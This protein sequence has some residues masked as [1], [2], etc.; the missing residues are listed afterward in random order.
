MCRQCLQKGENWQLPLCQEGRY[1]QAGCS[2]DIPCKSS[3]CDFKILRSPDFFFLEPCPAR[4][5][6]THICLHAIN[7]KSARPSCDCFGRA[8]PKSPDAT[9]AD[10]GRCC[11]ISIT[12]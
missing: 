5:S 3:S 6:T 4:A 12:E 10:V 8:Y 1:A 11:S 7:S 2:I 9:R